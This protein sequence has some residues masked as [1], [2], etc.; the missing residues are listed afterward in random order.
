MRSSEYQQSLAVRPNDV[1]TLMQL[2]VTYVALGRQAGAIA[3]FRRVVE[4]RSRRRR[5][6][7][8]SCARSS[9]T[10]RSKEAE[11]HA[12]GGGAP[13]APTTTPSRDDLGIALAGQGS[14][15]RRSPKI[16]AVVA[17][18]PQ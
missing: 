9:E 16:P 17:I 14:L 10:G 4:A 12:R 18:R 11:P 2:G 3:Q 6:A 5:R 15:T 13:A 7:P 1:S 8:Q